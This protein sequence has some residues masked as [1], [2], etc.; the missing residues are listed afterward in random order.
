[1]DFNTGLIPD[2]VQ[3]EYI[4]T[5]SKTIL[6]FIDPFAGIV[7]SSLISTSGQS[8][9]DPVQSAFSKFANKT[10]SDTANV[11]PVNFDWERNR[12]D[13]FVNA[14]DYKELGFDPAI[15]NETKFGYRQTWGDTIGSALAGGGGLAS[16]TFIEGWKGWG[17]IADAL[18][19]WDS[20]KLVGSD[21]EL[22][23]LSKEQDEIMNKYAIFSTPESEDTV[24]NRQ[25]LGN[26]LQ[27]G[28]FALG[29]IAQFASEELLTLGLST[30]ISG[31][32]LGFNVART[33]AV[34]NRAERIRDL[35][36]LGTEIYK[37]EKIVNGI[38]NGAKKL[39]PLVNTAQDITK[40]SRAGAGSLQLAY[41]GVGGVRR[42]LAEANMAF[43]EARMEAAGTY[44]DLYNRLKNEYIDRTG[45]TP[46]GFD[47][48]KIRE[49]AMNAGSD[50]FAVNSG[51]LM[52]ANRIQF[53]NLFSKFG[54]Q[55]RILKEM[56]QYADDVLKVS[57]KA[58]GDASEKITTRVYD[59]SGIFGTVGKY[60]DIA[61]DFGTKTARWEAG[62]AIAKGIFK[63]EA[64]E[65]IQE[66]LQESSNTA[67]QDYYYDLY[68]G[69]KGADLMNSINK[70]LKSQYSTQGMKTFL[71]GALTGRL[72]SPITYAGGK[73]VDKVRVNSETREEL[74]KAKEESIAT[75]NGFYSNP[76]NFLNEAI[77][78]VKVQQKAG[79]LMD[80]AADA[81]DIY[82]FTN[83]KDSAL[84][85]LVSA[86]KKTDM[87]ETV[88]DTIKD[89]SELMDGTQIKE[90][91]S[92]DPTEDNINNTRSFFTDVANKIESF[93]KSW[94]TLQDK[95]GDTV[96]PEIY[97]EGTEAHTQALIAKSALDSAIQILA[98]NKY[99]SE[100]AIE[101]AVS[102]YNEVSQNTAIGSS[103]SQVFKHLGSTQETDNQI[104]L[105]QAELSSLKS[106]PVPDKALKKQIK[107][108]EKQLQNLED[109]KVNW[110][111][112][113]DIKPGQK[114]KANKALKSFRE[115]I[116]S[117]NEESNL[118]TTV[119]ADDIRDTFEKL[120]DY[121][122]L[123][124][125]HKNFIDAYN[126]LA[127][128]EEFA[129]N[130][131]KM[132]N[133][134]NEVRER[135][136]AEH[137][138]EI[139]SDGITDEFMPTEEPEVTTT[140]ATTTVNNTNAPS[141]EDYLLEKYNNIKEGP[142]GDN[143]PNFDIWKQTA[144]NYFIKEYN[145]KFGKNENVV[146]NNNMPEVDL[147]EP[148]LTQ[149]EINDY[150]AEEFGRNALSKVT[151]GTYEIN[152]GDQINDEE[153]VGITEKIVNLEKSGPQSYD[154][155]LKMLKPFNGKNLTKKSNDPVSIEE[156]PLENG[157][158]ENLANIEN[159][160]TNQNTDRI[161]QDKNPG[162]YRDSDKVIQGGSK[163]NT[164]S[165]LYRVSKDPVQKRERTGPNPTYNM[166]MGTPTINVG[167]TITL[168]AET[169]IADY[170][171][172]VVKKKF[173]AADF[174][175]DNKI[176]DGLQN[177]FP[178]GIYA[179][180]DGKEVKLGNLPTL[181]WV[182]R[183]KAN[184]E[185]MNVLEFITN[186]DGS[187][188]NN[189]V[190]QVNK[191][192]ELRSNLY[193][194][195][196]KNSTF[197]LTA[198][199]DNKS[200]GKIRL[201][202]N[203]GKLKD[204]LHPSTKMGII[205][206]GVVT[207]NNDVQLNLPQEQI[208]S[209]FDFQGKEGW[210]VVLL[211]TPTGRTL[212]S[213]V[214][215][216][217][218]NSDYQNIIVDSWKAFHAVNNNPGIAKTSQEYKVVQAVYEAYGNTFEA[219]EQID[220]NVLRG[221]INDYVTYLSGEK[222]DPLKE[223]KSQL[224]ITPKG[225]LSLWVVDT[226]DVNQDSVFAA[227]PE[228][229]DNK[230]DNFM[231]KLASVYHNVKLS[232]STAV[233]VNSKDT[234]S[235][236]TYQNGKIAVAKPQT[237]NEYMM[238]ILETKI[239]KGTPINP[240]DKNSKFVY[241]ANPVV[242]FDQVEAPEIEQEAA[243]QSD[244]SSL[245]GYDKIKT[246]ITELSKDNYLYTHV[247]RNQDA[248]AIV[249]S[250]F[251]VSGGTGVSSTLSFLGKDSVLGQIDKLIKGEVVHRDTTNNSLVLIAVPKAVLDVN[252]IKEKAEALEIWLAEN[253]VLNASGQFVIPNQFNAGY[254]NGDTFVQSNNS[255]T[256]ES[257]ITPKVTTSSK[258]SQLQKEFEDKKAAF[259][260]VT[261]AEDFKKVG[262]IVYQPGKRDTSGPEAYT[263]SFYDPITN[264]FSIKD[265]NGKV[266]PM[267]ELN[268]DAINDLLHQEKLYN[269][270]NILELEYEYK[271]KIQKAKEDDAFE[272]VLA[273]NAAKNNPLL[274]A[275]P[276]EDDELDLTKSFG[277]T[278]FDA[279]MFDDATPDLKSIKTIIN[280]LNIP[281]VCN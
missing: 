156:S 75:L 163:I 23:A 160:T 244:S 168:R 182:E 215:V 90:A 261:P 224:S 112:L 249:D 33:A 169:D 130:H 171:D 174:F 103:A 87:L 139:L 138:A 55:R 37:S 239:D 209:N 259:T 6:D 53:N 194:N 167:T 240:R 34:I 22:L 256:Q 10:A 125:D 99:K 208:I 113:K 132:V 29:A 210:P 127:N 151:I 40:F 79:E 115:Y 203:L 16:Q 98:T 263:I 154:D 85:Q 52:L 95:Y 164:N 44:G 108:K 81:R 267:D 217:K 57:G 124:Q 41:L 64:S 184:G 190:E 74:R 77:A 71:M 254:L 104:S 3:P 105:L 150:V 122:E 35:S 107:I 157:E 218:L 173:T 36:R 80:I 137:E 272:A 162:M 56:G 15:N 165:D 262:T 91:F 133:A 152:V 176:K 237:Y 255:S 266:I 46:T 19:S 116:N 242:T 235:F 214:N 149:D 70:G 281:K 212:V 118:S 100:R 51:I 58:A 253:T 245:K 270:S 30:A 166:L 45:Q 17:K 199:V 201:T 265:K 8:N 264:L 251:V 175:D 274:Q 216:P 82:D 238:G 192:K 106:N 236:L 248:K 269:R 205:K 181:S 78:T 183:R 260:K 275:Q 111:A 38:L 59:K 177:E 147:E 96:M 204:R 189:L 109:W 202:Q 9:I 47:L 195:H 12:T 11:A 246:F 277:K 4:P 225:E 135:F 197:V 278:I 143:L 110:E 26:M 268:Q 86:A 219:N 232:S 63:W 273:K 48:D 24:F 191:L 60:K 88:L 129:K 5:A 136:K 21:E 227:T 148:E 76:A 66:L 172:E 226:K 18:F 257:V 233:G 211:D 120:V 54:P 231:E 207:L 42:A 141:L 61:A 247:T 180:V 131:T 25:F 14:S 67:L 188:T 178:V 280:Q 187:R 153:V 155:I 213:Y 7:N 83:A 250:N 140:E 229:F 62:K 161:I 234:K 31:T 20:S 193:N 220:F 43:T 28:G 228:E 279:G 196:N 252:G 119:L 221:Y 158:I 92:I 1:M 93:S 271:P 94:E 144:A 49:T 186:S 114:R 241:F 145:R 123:N 128:P 117:K 97:Q 142:N 2:Q 65:G 73:I 101:R 276:V 185:T 39:I 69:N 13:R 121:I 126:I 230:I 72:I 198:I 32:K 27:Q 102:I 243:A 200:E 170:T 146:S 68:H 84:A 223:G 222:Y 50:N 206:G 258:E 179:T 159:T 89:Y 134:L